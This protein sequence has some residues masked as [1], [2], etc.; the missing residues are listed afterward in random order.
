MCLFFNDNYDV[1]VLGCCLV[2][3]S[4]IVVAVFVIFV[5]LLLA[6]RQLSVA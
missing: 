5:A 6:A 4:S 3:K 1:F 2:E